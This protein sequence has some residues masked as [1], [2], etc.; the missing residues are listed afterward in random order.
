MDGQ[1]PHMGLDDIALLLAEDGQGAGV[2]QGELRVIQALVAG[3]GG[4]VVA[5]IKV[6]VMEKAAP[7]AGTVVQTVAAAQA[8]G[9]VR[10]KDGVL[11]AVDAGVVGQGT[12]GL[13]LRGLE[14][15]LDAGEEGHAVGKV[16]ELHRK[17]PFPGKDD[18]FGCPSPAWAGNDPIIAAFFRFVIR[19][20]KKH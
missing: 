3:M 14:E 12:H 11:V 2:A 19:K 18:V 13:N 6:E 16:D 8:E 15:I 17:N 9:Y 20:K 7:G 1:G 5:I 4:G 10:H